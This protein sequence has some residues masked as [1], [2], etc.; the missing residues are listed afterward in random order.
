MRTSAVIALALALAP[1]VTR[2]EQSPPRPVAPPA[3]TAFPAGVEVVNV[4]AVV[5][6][7]QGNPV[8]GLTQADFTIKEDGRPQTITGFEAVG[9]DESAAQA[10]AGP[11]RVSTNATPP[12]RGDRWFVVV[13][14]DA[15]LSAPA[16]PRAR[17]AITDFLDRGLRDGDQV[18]IVPTSGGAWWTGRMPEDHDTL[19]SFVDRLQGLWKPETGPERIW[20]HE[21]IAIAN[22]RDRQLEA[23][24]ARRYFENNLI[25]EAYPQDRELASVLSVSPG[26][27]MIR[28]KAREVYARATG[29]LR[30]TL[31]TLERVSTSLTQLRGRKSLL[32][33]SE[34]FI[35]DPS[36]SEFRDLIQAARNASTAVYF[37]DVRG[38]TGA[39]GQAGMAGGGAESGRAVEEQDTTTALALATAAAEGARSVAYD[40]GGAVI[41]GTRLADGMAK[42]ARQSRAYYLLGYT[43]TNPSRDGKFRKIQVSVGRP[44]SEVR[45]RR[46]YYAPS[47]TPEKPLRRDD[48]DPAVR[49]GLDS[50]A[51]SSGI[52]LRLTSYVFGPRPEGKRQVLLAGE[53]DL[54]PLRLAPRDGRYSA[55]LDT[56]VVVYG[57]D[58]AEPERQQT[59]IDLALPAD[60]YPQIARSGVPIR[61]EFALAPG[62]YQA[63]LLVK[64]LAT[65]LIGTV[66]HEFEVPANPGLQVTTPILTDSFQAGTSGQP[67]RPVPVAHRTFTAGARL[68]CVFSV[69]GAVTDPSRGRP[70][71][72]HAY[73]LRRADGTNVSASP[74]RVINADAGGQMTPAIFF[75]LP[76][77]AAGAFELALTLRDEVA[78]TTLDVVEPFTATRP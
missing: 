48:L 31:G 78:N 10:P 29:R 64:D 51:M 76:A 4:D 27:A 19:A 71:V 25:P 43:S 60:A 5:L 42:V 65:G 33:V 59:Q 14:D 63:R 77:D 36:Q 15:N 22:G 38:S 69:L 9:L 70:R 45:A 2:G 58:T 34:G 32:L 39:V 18:M 56:Y 44:K 40:T 37:V 16:A 23:E 61:R 1:S 7:D 54:A 72:T 3:S 46:G 28:A 73:R 21:A 6:D 50:L 52:P 66:R 57:L 49:N 68:A 74:A 62:R 41:E 11:Q 20:D 75:E 53:A 55:K 12:S 24:V 13:F 8:E 35:M 17:Q 67:P 26:V 30:A 47:A